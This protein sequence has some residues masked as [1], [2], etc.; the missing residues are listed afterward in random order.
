[1]KKLTGYK[2]I[3]KLLLATLL[4]LGMTTM[5]KSQSEGNVVVHE[6]PSIMHVMST[7]QQATKEVN[8]IPGYR[9]Q[10]FSD[11]GNRSR[12]NARRAKAQFRLRNS[13]I[14]AYVVFDAPNYKVEV[15]NFTTRLDAERVLRELQSQYQGAF[16]VAVDEMEVPKIWQ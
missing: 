15:G 14:P 12:E 1:M 8:G 6:P 5:A 9:V 7:Y 2:A 10:V 3:M 4:V 16:V 13:D 11:S